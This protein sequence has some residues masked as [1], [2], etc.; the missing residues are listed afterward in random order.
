MLFAW[1][2]VSLTLLKLFVVWL[3]VL[4]VVPTSLSVCAGGMVSLS[5]MGLGRRPNELGAEDDEDD[6]EEEDEEDEEEDEGN[7][8][9]GGMGM[10]LVLGVKTGDMEEV[11]EEEVVPDEVEDIKGAERWVYSLNTCGVCEMGESPS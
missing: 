5:E 7:C 3:V 9:E 11:V 2:L 8:S 10:E 6:E 1:E 4:F